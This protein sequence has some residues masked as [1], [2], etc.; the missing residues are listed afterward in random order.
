M[1]IRMRIYHSEN[2]NHEK[3]DE[4]FYKYV[5]PVHEKYGALFLDRYRDKAGKV[6]VMWQYES[7]EDML[8]IQEAAA[9][10]ENTK[11]Y[12][13]KRVRNGLHGFKF[14]EYILHPA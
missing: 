9:N 1:V 2:A 7:E 13:D 10:D 5:K 8:R 3:A 11:K 4:V 14:V 6:V 12:K